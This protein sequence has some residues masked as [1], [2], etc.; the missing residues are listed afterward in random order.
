M[1][2]KESWCGSFFL[3]F[4]KGRVEIKKK[5]STRQYMCLL[6]WSFCRKWGSKNK[7]QILHNRYLWR[8]HADQWKSEGRVP[9]KPRIKSLTWTKSHSWLMQ[10][11]NYSSLNKRTHHHLV[12]DKPCPLASVSLASDPPRSPMSPCVSGSWLSIISDLPRLQ[13]PDR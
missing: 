13:T 6:E 1:P 11:G 3:R 10:R 8:P 5:V 12:L 9:S 7:A 2:L 4:R